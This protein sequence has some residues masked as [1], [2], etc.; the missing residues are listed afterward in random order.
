MFI[1]N[2]L[3]V[4]GWKDNSPELMVKLL[5]ERSSTMETELIRRVMGET[6]RYSEKTWKRGADKYDAFDIHHEISLRKKPLRIL[7]VGCG[8]AFVFSELKSKYGLAIE[9]YGISVMEHPHLED[10]NY[11]ICPAEIMPQEWDNFF[12]IILTHQTFCYMINPISA[13]GEC[14][15]VLK[16]GGIFGGYIGTI[17]HE[18]RLFYNPNLSD[19]LNQEVERTISSNRE[20]YNHNFNKVLSDFPFGFTAEVL[21]GQKGF[22]HKIYLVKTDEDKIIKDYISY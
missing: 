18:K 8:D 17:D 5:G 2:L 1:N 13:L 15:R 7:D 9:C 10:I 3:T 14:V 11:L 6:A 22:P 20:R 12:D 21:Y 16:K 19:E 4:K